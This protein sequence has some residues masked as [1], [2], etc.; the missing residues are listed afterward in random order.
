MSALD[1]FHTAVTNALKKEGWTIT[2]D[3]YRIISGRRNLY[4]DLGAEKLVAAERG[5]EKIAV[6]I[7]TF[8][9]KSDIEVPYA[10]KSRSVF[11]F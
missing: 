6:E 7:K 9:G 8:A 3:P 5:I 10:N 1:R 11:Y 4:V 2:H